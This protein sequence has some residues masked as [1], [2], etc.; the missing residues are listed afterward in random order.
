MAYTLR[1]LQFVL[2]QKVEEIEQRDE[3]IDEL[4]NE[5]DKKDEII[6]RLQNEVDKC[7]SVLNTKVC[8][9]S[10]K[11]ADD[12]PRKKRTAISAEPPKT[13]L[14]FPAHVPKEAA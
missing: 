4:E 3:L 12:K 1:E 11:P 8:Q 9:C 5:I 7:R 10:V 6:S 13:L 14:S 2:R